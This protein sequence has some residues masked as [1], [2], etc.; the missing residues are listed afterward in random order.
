MIRSWL[1]KAK[2]TRA[3]WAGVR[4][5]PKPLFMR[6]FFVALLTRFS[7]VLLSV[8]ERRT[9]VLVLPAGTNK[10]PGAHEQQWLGRAF[11]SACWVYHKLYLSEALGG[12]IYCRNGCFTRFA[13]YRCCSSGQHCA[14]RVAAAGNCAQGISQ[15]ASVAGRSPQ[16][17]KGSLIRLP[18]L[19]TTCSF[20]PTRKPN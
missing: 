14:V 6:L 17:E 8:T 10:A 13:G 5:F 1:S 16:K 18:L 19:L 15:L 20:D 9:Y 2:T 4:V 7:A 12:W 11:C 3:V